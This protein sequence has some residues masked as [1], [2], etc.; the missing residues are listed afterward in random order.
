MTLFSAKSSSKEIFLPK[1]QIIDE[2][3]F[4][5]IFLNMR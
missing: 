3:V 5:K 2:E 4:R 1:D